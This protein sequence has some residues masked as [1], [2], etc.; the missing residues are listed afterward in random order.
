MRRV[1]PIKPKLSGGGR[2]PS[3]RPDQGCLIW[4][5]EVSSATAVKKHNPGR[6]YVPFDALLSTQGMGTCDS[7]ASTL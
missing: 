1:N 4:W 3:G 7:E 5:P 2:V 6:N